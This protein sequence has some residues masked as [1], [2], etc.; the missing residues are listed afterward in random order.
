MTQMRADRLEITEQD[1]LVDFVGRSMRLAFL[2]GQTYWAQADSD[3]TKQRQLSDETG[4]TF[5][6][7]ME[8]TRLAVGAGRVI[9]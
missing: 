6:E 2:L 9:R 1:E 4:R 7:L 5:I 3:S 8:K